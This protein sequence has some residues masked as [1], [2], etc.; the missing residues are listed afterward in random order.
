MRG[1]PRMS[2]DGVL[3]LAVNA[4]SSIVHIVL[5]KLNTCHM[6]IELI[7]G[8]YGKTPRRLVGAAAVI[9]YLKRA[10]DQLV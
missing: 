2:W 8:P 3:P 5:I 7:C 1:W 9:S 10:S 6:H 4:G